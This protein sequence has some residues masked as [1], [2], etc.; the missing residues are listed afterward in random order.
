MIGE[1]A[2]VS[3]PFLPQSCSRPKAARTSRA[4]IPHRIIR[5]RGLVRSGILPRL[6]FGESQSSWLCHGQSQRK[7]LKTTSDEVFA[8]LALPVL[9]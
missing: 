4:E 6:I 3:C 9:R 1:L 5:F 7:R 2:S 8:S